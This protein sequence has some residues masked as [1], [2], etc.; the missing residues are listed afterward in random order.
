MPAGEIKLSPA[1]VE[2]MLALGIGKRLIAKYAQSFG[3]GS[4][5]LAVGVLN[6]SFRM[7]TG[8][9]DAKQYL[10]RNE[11]LIESEANGVCLD[12]EL[13]DAFSLLYSFMLIRIGPTD[14]VRSQALALRA[15]ELCIPLRTPEEICHSSDAFEFLSY[16]QRYAGELLQR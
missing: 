1:Q 10:L 14:P 8:G 4:N 6:Y 7:E 5:F 15:S 2:Y 13:E 3:D 12:P 16:V 9:E 11:P